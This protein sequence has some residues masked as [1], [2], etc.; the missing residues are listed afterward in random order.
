M[1]RATNNKNNIAT[2]S[3]M[4]H[5]LMV[6]PRLYARYRWLLGPC[7][8]A[9]GYASPNTALLV[10]DSVSSWRDTKLTHATQDWI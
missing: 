9:H 6:G 8:V 4:S 5:D 7:I 2:D 3:L 1:V 10:A